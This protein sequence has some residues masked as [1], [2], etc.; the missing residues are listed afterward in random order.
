[1]DKKRREMGSAIFVAIQPIAGCASIPECGNN[2]RLIV[3]LII[4]LLLTPH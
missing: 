3:S 2:Y 1:M 4:S